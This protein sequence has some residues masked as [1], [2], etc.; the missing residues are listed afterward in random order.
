[1]TSK[2]KSR[3]SRSLSHKYLHVVCREV[4]GT[5]FPYCFLSLY[6][7]FNWIG[8]W[9]ADSSHYLP[10]FCGAANRV[11]GHFC[12]EVCITLCVRA[13]FILV[14]TLLSAEVHLLIFTFP[15]RI[16]QTPIL[17][18]A[19]VL[20]MEMKHTCKPCIWDCEILRLVLS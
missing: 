17:L 11:K 7:N 16:S 20:F 8:C 1:M 15:N 6:G 12:R 19:L 9:S 5:S 4:P 10:L 2:I 13:W 18:T 14:L 3:K